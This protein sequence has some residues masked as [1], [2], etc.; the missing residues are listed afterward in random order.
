MSPHKKV[1][2]LN[3][4]ITDKKLFDY[5]YNTFQP[6]DTWA[7][8]LRRAKRAEF[9]LKALKEMISPRQLAELESRL[10]KDDPQPIEV[11]A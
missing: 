9:E 4:T 1:K 7:E 11:L 5:F 3:I 8:R 6:H 10:R 2:Q